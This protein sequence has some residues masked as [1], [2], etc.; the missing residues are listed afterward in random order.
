M[1]RQN[2]FNSIDM[3]FL[4]SFD[5]KLGRER[6]VTI[7]TIASN[8]PEDAPT[9]NMQGWNISE[10]NA[11]LATIHPV[12]PLFNDTTME[13]AS[14]TL[15]VWRWRKAA[16]QGTSDPTGQWFAEE[17]FTVALDGNMTRDESMERIFTTNVAEKIYLQ[18]VGRSVG[19]VSSTLTIAICFYGIGPRRGE[20]DGSV[21]VA[22]NSSRPII[23]ASIAAILSSG[24]SFEGDHIYSNYRDDFTA[25][26]AT[27]STVTLA[28][29]PAWITVTAPKIV[30][31]GIKPN[32][33]EED[34]DFIYVRGSGDLKVSYAAGTITFDT[35]VLIANY[36]I[37]VWIEEIP[38]YQGSNIDATYH[39]KTRDE[40]FTVATRSERT[41]EIDPIDTKYVP[42]TVADVTNGA[43]ATYDYFLDMATFRKLGL[44]LEL[45]SGTSTPTV[46]IYGTLQDDGT[47]AA[48]CIYQDIGSATFGAASWTTD[49][50][51][52]DNSEKLACYKYIKVEVVAAGGGADADW[53]IYAKRLY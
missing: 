4:P 16:N 42:D 3:P 47:A 14:V 48:S 36:E 31:I 23:D 6:Q 7:S 52:I 37:G 49:A 18:I 24:V 19:A 41:E 8:W 32:T 26:I 45:A 22:S 40:A 27:T 43:D 51:L 35:P 53:T 2:P 10:W 34:W 39:L 9:T 25:T 28:A 1:K 11:V 15:R 17:E 30:A 12:V 13:D 21:L 38:R 50:M 44:H 33:G 29:L 5:T 46:K 20:T